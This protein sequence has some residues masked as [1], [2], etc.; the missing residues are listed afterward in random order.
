MRS[1]RD[2]AADTSAREHDCALVHL[3]DEVVIERNLAELVDDHGGVARVRMGQEPGDERRLPAS[4]EAG[5]Q[6]D[7]QPLSQARSANPDQAD[8]VAGLQADSPLTTGPPG[9]RRQPTH[10]CRP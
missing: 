8:R 1:S 2:S 3:P 5:D 7:R 10:R 9:Y 4:E 6:S